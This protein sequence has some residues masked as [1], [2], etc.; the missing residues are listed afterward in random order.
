MCPAE[1]KEIN[2]TLLK[3]TYTFIMNQ[4]V[5]LKTSWFIDA[6][7]FSIPQEKLQWKDK[8]ISLNTGAITAHLPTS[9]SKTPGI[10]QTPSIGIKKQ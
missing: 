7:Y 5:R 10:E 9:Q 6:L 4:N 2:I 1:L 3:A 8:E